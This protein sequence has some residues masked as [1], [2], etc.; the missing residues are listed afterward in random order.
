VKFVQNCAYNV[1]ITALQSYK[2][3]Y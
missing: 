2:F 1:A 3:S